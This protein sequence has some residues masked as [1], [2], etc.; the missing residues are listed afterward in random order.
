[1]QILIVFFII[2]NITLKKDFKIL[3]IVYKR[4]MSKEMKSTKRSKS[5]P[6]TD[7]D[8]EESREE[9]RK[10]RNDKLTKLATT[11]LKNSGKKSA[12][13]RSAVSRPKY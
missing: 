5:V 3:K 7:S 10:S 9:V 1:M 12:T 6:K 4:T 8:K 2:L 13:T 11:D